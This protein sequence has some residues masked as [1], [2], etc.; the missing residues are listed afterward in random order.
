MKSAGLFLLGSIALFSLMNAQEPSAN[1]DGT[2]APKIT[3]QPGNQ[4]VKVG[5]KATFKVV[6]SGTAPLKYQWYEWSS[7][8][9]GANSAS[10]TTAATVDSDNGAQF[11]VVVSNTAGSATSN[12]VSLSVVDP[13]QIEEQPQSMTV[14]APGVA[15]FTVYA[16]GTQPLKYQ[17]YK[18]GAAITGATDYTYSTA[19]TSTADSGAKFTVIV[20]N[21]AGKVTSAPATLT[22]NPYNG[23]G[24]YPLVGEWTGTATITDSMGSKQ[25]TQVVAGFWQ[26]SYSLAG[27]I[28]FVDDYGD[29][30]MGSGIASLNNLNLFTTGDT[31][32][33]ETMNLAGG[34]SSNLLNFTGQAIAPD[35]EGGSGN[36]VLSA[37]HNT[38]TGSAKIN[39][40]T[41]MSWKLTR[42]Q[43]K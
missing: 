26:T 25:T 41:T 29:L 31:G 28:V 32:D 21:A 33:G 19:E 5:T 43:S 23:T 39:D 40:G 3:T 36:L 37:D 4:T 38:L 42:T 17:W 11:F 7:A 15:T 14:T 22:V 13:P 30:E 24:T 16:Q 6:A 2:A 8:I 1:P 12:T 9:N 10:Y 35:G 18:R 20:S 34:F 27:T